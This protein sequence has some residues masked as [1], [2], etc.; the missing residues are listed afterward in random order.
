[1]LTREF[2]YRGFLLVSLCLTGIVTDSQASDFETV[3]NSLHGQ[4]LIG[5]TEAMP[6]N[7]NISMEKARG[8]WES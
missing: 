4:M 8:H 1:M 3:A 5:K 6:V 7:E 2:I